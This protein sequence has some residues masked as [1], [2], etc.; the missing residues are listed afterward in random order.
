M[1]KNPFSFSGRIRRFEYGLSL[2]IYVAGLVIIDNNQENSFIGFMVIPLVWFLFSQ[3]TKRC[4]DL[5]HS[6]WYQILPFYV[7]WMIFSEGTTGI[8]NYG[9]NPKE[10]ETEQPVI[11][12]PIV[13]ATPAPEKK[14]PVTVPVKDTKSVV[15]KIESQSN[16]TSVADVVNS[17]KAAKEQGRT[18]NDQETKLEVGNVDTTITQNILMKLRSLSIINS[19]SYNNYISTAVITINHK[20]TS[21]D[22]LD[23]LYK[24]MPD[25]ELNG[26]KEGHISIKIK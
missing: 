23:E 22:L 15:S 14:I 26:V 18:V 12:T 8:N 2:L 16:I 4:H 20:K 17:L 13:T 10:G 9:A 7:L 3:G 11:V 24:M 21:Q 1:F 25:I 19:L 5:N 6:G